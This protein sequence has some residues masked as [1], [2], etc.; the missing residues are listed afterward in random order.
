MT[1]KGHD[2]NN[3]YKTEDKYLGLYHILKEGYLLI[4]P[5]GYRENTFHIFKYCFQTHTK[6]QRKLIVLSRAQFCNSN[7]LVE[8]FIEKEE[9]NFQEDAYLMLSDSKIEAA[10]IVLLWCLV[11]GK[12]VMTS[13]NT[14]TIIHGCLKCQQQRAMCSSY[15]TVFLEQIKWIY[16]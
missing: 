10:T 15:T 14:D 13:F 4:G 12:A 2:Q 1:G 8:T 16:F 3:N 6:R 9:L 11:Q 5:F 7:S